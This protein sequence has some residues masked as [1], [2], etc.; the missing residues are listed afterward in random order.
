MY[1]CDV[2]EVEG[3]PGQ[4]QF[5]DFTVPFLNSIM[6]G[7]NCIA[8]CLREDKPGNCENGIICLV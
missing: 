4:K 2:R 5:F 6:F 8:A 7:F 1:V 3:A